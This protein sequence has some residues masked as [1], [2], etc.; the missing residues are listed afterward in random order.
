VVAAGLVCAFLATAAAAWAC[1]TGPTMN[2]TPDHPMAGQ[3]VTLSGFNW[4]SSLPIVVRWNSF[5]GPVLG[6]FMP[7]PGRFGDPELL[8]GTVTIPA[9]A[10]AGPDVLIAT[11]TGRDGKLANIPVRALVTVTS[12]GGGPLND[13]PVAPVE[14][15]RPV[16]PARASSSVSTGALVLV[17]LGATGVAL[18]I[19]GMAT[20]VSGRRRLESE[21]APAARR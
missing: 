4:G 11:Q 1:V 15:N 9:D 19:A 17:G 6:T 7:A 5:D 18:F 20:F 14:L 10:K 8:R 12:P 21:M 3:T 13:V 16:G 2:V